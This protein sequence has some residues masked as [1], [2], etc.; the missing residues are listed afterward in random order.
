MTERVSVTEANKA[1]TRR[2][3]EETWN[4][5]NLAIIDELVD[6]TFIGDLPAPNQPLRG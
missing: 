3:A 1:I 4:R 6:P 5:G 2:F